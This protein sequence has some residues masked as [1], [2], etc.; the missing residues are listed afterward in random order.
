MTT[1][2]RVLI[3]VSI[4]AVPALVQA[5]PAQIDAVAASPSQFRVLLDNEHVRL[6]EYVLQPGERDQWHTHPP[7]VSYVVE[8]GALRIH[9][10]DGTSFL[11][12]ETQGE[13]V[14]MGALPRHYAENVGPT[15]VRIV[16]VE[17]KSAAA[18]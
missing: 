1:L 3:A 16:L 15:P 2:T 8:G 9:L 11:S 5:Q 18:D 4:A 7:K 17:V 10:E 6:L 14:W 12:E 13:A